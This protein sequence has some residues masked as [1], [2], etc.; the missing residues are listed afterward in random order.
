HPPPQVD[1]LVLLARPVAPRPEPA[2]LI[3]LEK[4]VRSLFHVRR[5]MLSNTL[6]HALGG[7]RE[8]A[9]ALLAADGIPPATRPERVPPAV[10]LRW[11]TILA[12]S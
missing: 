6:P 11:A 8:R 2:V 12:A 4:L 1:S 10:F 7:N 3:V 5:K 9:L